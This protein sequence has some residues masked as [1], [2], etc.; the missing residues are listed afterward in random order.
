MQAVER[1][2]LGKNLDDVHHSEDY[3]E[4]VAAWV[5]MK[6]EERFMKIQ[7]R[8]QDD[9]KR[10]PQMVHQATSCLLS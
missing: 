9:L 3:E 6:K 5:E 8:I 4:T 2:G 10:L 7:Q 1:L